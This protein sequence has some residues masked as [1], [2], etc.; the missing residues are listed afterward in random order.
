MATC[1][2]GRAKCNYLG[3]KFAPSTHLRNYTHAPVL[4]ILLYAGLLLY[5]AQGESRSGNELELDHI[6]VILMSIMHVRIEK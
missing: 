6:S 1:C 3:V 2:D 5:N 4:T